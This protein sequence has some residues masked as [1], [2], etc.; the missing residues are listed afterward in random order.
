M[1]PSFVLLHDKLTFQCVVWAQP[2][3]CLDTKADLNQ[4]SLKRNASH[5]QQQTLP[6]TEQS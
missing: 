6:I 5:E 4:Q 3:T 2:L 1:E